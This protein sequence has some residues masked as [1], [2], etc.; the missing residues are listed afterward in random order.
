MSKQ[1]LNYQDAFQELEEI[2]TK[3]ESEEIDIDQITTMVK[4]ANQLITFCQDKL[5]KIENEL[6]SSSSEN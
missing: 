6:K 4:R 2:S 3:I 1:K 5:R